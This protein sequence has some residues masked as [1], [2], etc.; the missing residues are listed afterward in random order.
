[1]SAVLVCLRPDTP[2]ALVWS[3]GARALVAR[4]PAMLA[5]IEAVRLAAAHRA[6]VLLT[7]ESGAGKEVIARAL[8]AWSGRARGPFIAVN[9]AAL[10]E[11]LVEAELFGWERG[12]FTGAV[13]RREGR[14]E[15]AAGGTLLL[16]EVG[17]LSPAAQAKLLRVLQ[18]REVER[19]GGAGRRPIPVDVRV[20]A[21]THRDLRAR[22][23]AGL[24]RADLYFRLCG[25]PVE[26]PP[27]RMRPL[28]VLP[29]AEFFLA[30]LA[31]PARPPPLAPD[32]AAALVSWR[33][34]GNV[35][36]LENALERGFIRAA[37][38]GVLRAAHL[39]LEVNALALEP[40]AAAAPGALRENERR[41]ILDALSQAGGNRTRAAALLGMS[42]RTLR[43]RLREY[44]M[45]GEPVPPPVK[46]VALEG[47]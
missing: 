46:G 13:E 25:Y 20:V 28:D 12:A 43:H 35:R 19:L 9:C 1:M 34:P 44:R 4:D 36:E 31:A 40:P 29:L 3:D 27:L 5:A 17:E 10:P 6:T 32:A 23:A 16:D 42:L 7:G 38:G 37:P 11:A 8:H 21:T 45:H 18:E 47:A 26:L 41:L 14:I 24:F 15:A 30:R 33:W 39:A 2:D 22:V